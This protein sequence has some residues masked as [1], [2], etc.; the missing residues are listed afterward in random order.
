[1]AGKSWKSGRW[2]S[3]FDLGCQHIIRYSKVKEAK[4]LNSNHLVSR[5]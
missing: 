1:M 2:G 4:V 3:I 5:A